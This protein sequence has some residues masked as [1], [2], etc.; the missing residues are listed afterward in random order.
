MAD[1]PMQRRD[2]IYA[3]YLAASPAPTTKELLEMQVYLD[4]R[5]LLARISVVS[6]VKEEKE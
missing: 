2:L 4:M 5:D 6:S 1:V 3:A